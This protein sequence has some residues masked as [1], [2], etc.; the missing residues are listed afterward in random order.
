MTDSLSR[1]KRQKTTSIRYQPNYN[2]PSISTDKKH[3]SKKSYV[4]NENEVSRNV[5][6]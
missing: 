5:Q 3:K 4:L 1:A 2:L 6:S